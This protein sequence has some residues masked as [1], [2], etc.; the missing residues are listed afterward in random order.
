M[1]KDAL[2]KKSS[3]LGN[4]SL[5][6]L[7]LMLFLAILLRL[8]NIGLDVWN[9]E[10]YYSSHLFLANQAQLFHQTLGF[11]E[12]PFYFIFNFFWIRL[13]GDSE[14]SI[15]IPPLV[16]GIFSVFFTYCLGLKLFGRKVAFLASFLL[17]LSPVHIW[18][19]QEASAYS[20][21][22]CFLLFSVFSYYKLQERDV[23]IIWFF[24]Y[25]S[26]L[27]LAIFTH[28]V[29][30]I[31]LVA[32]SMLCLFK[33]SRVKRNVLIINIFI[34][35]CVMLFFGFKSRYGK[36]VT[37]VPW[38]YSFTPFEAWRVYFNWF[39]FGILLNPQT[40]K[41][42]VLLEKPFLFIP[43]VIFFIVFVKGMLLSFKKSNNSHGLDI[44]FYV[45]LLPLFMLL[46]PVI[47]FKNIYST[48]YLVFLLPFYYFVIAKGITGLTNKS[49]RMI[50]ICVT[51]VFSIAMFV[52][53][54]VNQDFSPGTINK[55]IQPWSQVVY[56]LLN[57][58]HCEN[59]VLQVFMAFPREK[60]KECDKRVI[61]YYLKKY[62][63]RI[64]CL[65]EI[66][67]HWIAYDN[68]FN[69]FPASAMQYKPTLFYLVKREFEPKY[70]EEFIKKILGDSRFSV[71]DSKF[72]N[73]LLVYK[74]KM[75]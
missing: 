4:N 72:F 36:I 21:A 13:F 64:P 44:L 10:I 63:E 32:I 71:L 47:G 31:Y 65:T 2:D 12:A 69:N 8:P 53:Y 57:E 22:L 67:T 62:K 56:F 16:C 74:I 43:Q 52:I 34:T 46:L 40:Y 55:R 19:S 51:I 75:K 27:F 37:G 50:G 7:S 15:R 26:T 30:F 49:M 29:T 20:M 58:A 11:I 9:D 17:C 45:F 48:R 68:N 59:S 73:G 35:C 5:L 28:W 25:F 14:I 24:I 54:S 61:S 38:L 23:N 41:I 60:C 33:L 39:V 3:I 66:R 42:K 1:N 6:F 70:I 18:Y